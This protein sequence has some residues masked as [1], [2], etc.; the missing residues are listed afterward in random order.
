[1]MSLTDNN[2]KEE[3]NLGFPKTWGFGHILI[4]VFPVL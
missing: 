3:V 4:L 2:S 1:M